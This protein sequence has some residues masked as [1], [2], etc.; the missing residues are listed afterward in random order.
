MRR[1]RRTWAHRN[2]LRLTN[3]NRQSKNILLTLLPRL[4]LISR[5]KDVDR[6]RDKKR[7]KVTTQVAS[8]KSPIEVPL[9]PTGGQN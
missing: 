8:A 7:P 5:E 4:V 6:F 9:A 3:E 2:V 1:R